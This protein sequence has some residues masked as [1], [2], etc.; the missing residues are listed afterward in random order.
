MEEKSCSVVYGP[1][2]LELNRSA[3]VRA[4]TNVITISLELN[5]TETAVALCYQLTASNATH[6]VIV[7]GTLADFE[8]DSGD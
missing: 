3:G 4:R 8:A 7:N 2:E 5:E 6:S 1:C